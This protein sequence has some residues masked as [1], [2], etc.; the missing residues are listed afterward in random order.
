MLHVEY[1]IC[2]CL[3]NSRDIVEDQLLTVKGVISFTVDMTNQRCA[4]RLRSDVKPE[5]SHRF[6]IETK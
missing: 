2:G 6:T 4:V 1:V 3:Q 5:V